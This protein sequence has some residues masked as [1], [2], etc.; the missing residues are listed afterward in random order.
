MTIKG[1]LHGKSLVFELELNTV[2]TCYCSLYYRFNVAIT[3]ARA[4]LVV[5]G[6]PRVL[7]ED[8][9]WHHVLKHCVKR[10][11]YWY[12]KE[13]DVAMHSS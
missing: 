8:K 10:S 1:K 5:I 3:R 2:I 6:H 9:N 7:A 11:S 13:N 4:L 12:V